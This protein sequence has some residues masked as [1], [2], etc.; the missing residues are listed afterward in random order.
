MEI[1]RAKN[2]ATYIFFPL[3]DYSG[4]LATSVAGLDSEIDT[5]SDAS[6]PNGFT[7][8]TNEATEI[9]TTGWH[10]LLVSQSEMN[11]DYI[12]IQVKGTSIPTQ[13]I[14]IR[15]TPAPANIKQ[16]NSVTI[17]GAGTA[18]DPWGPA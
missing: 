15:T 6:A 9:G 16:V 10:Y 18:G 7:D 11:A 3:L 5:W 12:A 1:V 2:V 8:C 17:D 13:C 14:L 4:A